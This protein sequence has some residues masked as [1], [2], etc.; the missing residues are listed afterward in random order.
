MLSQPDPHRQSED[1]GEPAAHLPLRNISSEFQG[2]R[3]PKAAGELTYQDARIRLRVLLADGTQN[4]ERFEIEPLFQDEAVGIISFDAFSSSVREQLTRIV[5]GSSTDGL[6][7]GALFEAVER[8]ANECAIKFSPYSKH[9]AAKMED[10]S[11]GY[12]E[13]LSTRCPFEVSDLSAYFAG[14]DVVRIVVRRVGAD[15]ELRGSMQARML[16]NLATAE[17]CAV[18]KIVEGEKRWMV[19]VP[20]EGESAAPFTVGSLVEEAISRFREGGGDAVVAPLAPE[21]PGDDTYE[22]K[23]TPRGEH[24]GFM[25]AKSL[26]EFFSSNFYGWNGPLHRSEISPNDIKEVH[27]MPSGAVIQLFRSEKEMGI[28]ISADVDPE[29]TSVI[30]AVPYSKLTSWFRERTLRRA[31]DMLCSGDAKKQ[32][33]AIA[34]IDRYPYSVCLRWRDQHDSV[35]TE[36]GDRVKAMGGDVARWYPQSRTTTKY[37]LELLQGF[38]HAL[39]VKPDQAPY[40][41][42]TL[43]FTLNQ[44][45]DGTMQLKNRFGHSLRFALPPLAE[46]DADSLFE[47]RMFLRECVDV[48]SRSPE[49][50]IYKLFEEN[51]AHEASGLWFDS[52][53]KEWRL[54]HH[55]GKLF[56]ANAAALG[57][58]LSTAALIPMRELGWDNG[59]LYVPIRAHP[60]GPSMYFKGNED[61]ITS[62]VLAA[63]DRTSY[64]SGERREFFISAKESADLNLQG[65]LEC[66]HE[67]ET[68]ADI[69]H[70]PLVSKIAA[71]SKK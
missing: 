13:I 2:A 19:G 42:A 8:E 56:E 53:P 9:P 5:Q 65:L 36:L 58:K 47:R 48:F 62:I 16:L 17:S 33:R 70:S 55:L 66:F 63:P 22:K 30:Y 6:L 32:E 61:G 27:E 45:G 49:E 11:G 60:R 44:S 4:V 3:L 34:R 38:D 10:P 37:A 59:I 51:L 18:L 21:E 12:T 20:A 24:V 54:F 31:F 25:L 40:K 15:G 1:R 26:P 64:G 28:L 52:E 35:L 69:L 67:S 23:E 43:E 7:A 41:F 50:L 68:Q 14:Q 71:I 57:G 29:R 46:I 39:V